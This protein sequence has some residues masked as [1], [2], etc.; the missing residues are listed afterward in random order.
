M[1]KMMAPRMKNED[2]I[3]M[4]QKRNI[5]YVMVFCSL[6]IPYGF[7]KDLSKSRSFES[8]ML[9]AKEDTWK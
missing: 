6:K 7:L 4:L 2:A 9:L 5:K 8:Y 1:K 3:L